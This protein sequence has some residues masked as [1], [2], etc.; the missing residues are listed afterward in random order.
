[1]FKH[2]YKSK[3]V[4]CSLSRIPIL[5][6]S[7]HRSNVISKRIPTGMFIETDKLISKVYLDIKGA[8]NRDGNLED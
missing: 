1:M 2:L 7:G 8:K 4:L 3:E 6:K 5:L